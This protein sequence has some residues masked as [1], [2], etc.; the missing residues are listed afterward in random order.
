MI[1][2]QSFDFLVRH[3]SPARTNKHSDHCGKKDNNDG[4]VE[5]KRKKS[6]LS[7]H[8]TKSN[9]FQVDTIESNKK[10]EKTK[11]G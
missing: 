9:E 11:T 6:R 1:P 5:T 8:K 10:E 7:A 3:S 2:I 4:S